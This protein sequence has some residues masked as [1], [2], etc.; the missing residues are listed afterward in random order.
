MHPAAQVAGQMARDDFLTGLSV[1]FGP[2]RSSWSYAKVWDPD[3]GPQGLDHVRRHEAR[4]HEVG[5][6]PAPAYREAFVYGVQ[7]EAIDGRPAPLAEMPNC[8]S[9]NTACTDARVT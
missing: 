9:G 6:T 4:L 7:A 8:G 2:I 1:G 5:L 3:I